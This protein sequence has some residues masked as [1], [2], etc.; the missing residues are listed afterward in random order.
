MFGTYW[1][2][3]VS[4]YQ[5]KYKLNPKSVCIY[6]T[7][8]SLYLKKNAAV[9]FFTNKSINRSFCNW[10]GIASQESTRVRSRAYMRGH[11]YY[12]LQR[13]TEIVMSAVSHSSD[14]H[15]H[16]TYSHPNRAQ[17]QKLKIQF[18]KMSLPLLVLSTGP[19]YCICTLYTA[20]LGV[21]TSDF[22]AQMS[23]T[24]G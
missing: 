10:L 4:M 15:I 12:I 23:G 20:Q 1:Q 13:A 16:T 6:F 24:K 18:Q 9:F 19:T 3:Y 17:T 14:C 22:D 2:W 11:M 5:C 8:S 21:G 7:Q